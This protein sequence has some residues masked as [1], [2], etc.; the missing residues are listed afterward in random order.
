MF[1][2]KRL[3]AAVDQVTNLTSQVNSLTSERDT[4]Q[5][6]VTELEGQQNGLI[7]AEIHNAVV[8]ERDNLQARVAQLEG[9]QRTAGEQAADINANLGVPPVAAE[10]LGST[11]EAKSAKELKQEFDAITDPKAKA[12]FWAKHREEILR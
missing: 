4:L 7:T 10:G 8:L 6:R 11:S 3:Q 2:S 1:A 5:A 9:E 12:A